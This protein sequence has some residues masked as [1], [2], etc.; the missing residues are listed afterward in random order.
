MQQAE[1]L[2][3]ET[4]A[5]GLTLSTAIDNLQAQSLY[6]SCGYDRDTQFFVYNRLLE[7]DRP[8]SPGDA[9]GF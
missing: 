9:A 4:G 5:V 6:E 2:A 1:K 7:L 8:D 3:Y